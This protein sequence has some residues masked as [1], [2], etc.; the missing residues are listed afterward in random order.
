[1]SLAPQRT[2]DGR[3]PTGGGVWLMGVANKFPYRV[4]LEIILH[5][6]VVRIHHPALVLHTNTNK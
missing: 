1:M 4:S 5:F 6:V 2:S 3:T